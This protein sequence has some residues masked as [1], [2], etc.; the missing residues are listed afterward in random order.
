MD[1][2]RLYELSHALHIIRKSEKIESDFHRWQTSSTQSIYQIRSSKNQIPNHSYAWE[3]CPINE[4]VY[5]IIL[6]RLAGMRNECKSIYWSLNRIC[7]F[8]HIAFTSSA[9]RFV[10]S[11]ICRT[12]CQWNLVELFALMTF[13]NSQKFKFAGNH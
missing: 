1:D 8:V 7:V 11:D 5:M 13:Q 3:W 4:I 10:H 9:L 12:A 2:I 6:K